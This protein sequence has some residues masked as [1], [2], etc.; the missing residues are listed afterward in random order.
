MVPHPDGCLFSSC[1]CQ[2]SILFTLHPRVQSSFK[3]RRVIVTMALEARPA[4]LRTMNLTGMKQNDDD[5]VD[6]DDDPR[7]F[8][9]NWN[10]DELHICTDT[11]TSQLL[12]IFEQLCHWFCPSP[13]VLTIVLA[14][15]STGTCTNYTFALTH[16]H[17]E[18][19]T[20]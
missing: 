7:L 11:C 16:A 10:M 18:C 19:C 8:K 13:T 14:Y 3:Q 2:G 20:F 4:R 15:T 5:D 6:D 9:V 17:H 12:H 1:W